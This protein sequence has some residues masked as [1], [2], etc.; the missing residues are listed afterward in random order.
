MLPRSVFP[1]ELLGGVI[2]QRATPATADA[3]VRSGV[4]P[5]FALQDTTPE[6]KS[7]PSLRITGAE[8]TNGLPARGFPLRLS[9]VRRTA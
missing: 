2:E 4:V 1:F 3:R 5:T 8:T 6:P 9:A 7:A